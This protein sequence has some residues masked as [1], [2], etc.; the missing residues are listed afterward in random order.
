MGGRPREPTHRR[1][2]PIIREL[3]SFW[4]CAH[5]EKQLQEVVDG[6]QEVVDARAEISVNIRRV[7]EVPKVSDE[8]RSRNIVPLAVRHEQCIESDDKLVLDLVEVA[9]DVVLGDDHAV[10]HVHGVATQL[11]MVAQ[12]QVHDL[13][14]KRMEC[15]LIVLRIR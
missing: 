4:Q 2:H 9:G 7:E 8:E 1:D 5:A 13:P 12:T 14:N 6:V 11:I 10:E 15:D 3:I